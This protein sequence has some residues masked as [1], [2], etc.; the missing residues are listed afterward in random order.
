MAKS[1][2]RLYHLKN[3]KTGEERLVEAITPASAVKHVN[4]EWEVATATSSVAFDLAGKGVKKETAAK[5][6]AEPAA[7]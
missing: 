4:S 6:A 2:V 1:A 7:A 5:E 3:T